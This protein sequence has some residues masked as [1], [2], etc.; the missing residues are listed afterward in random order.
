LTLSAIK[1]S[2]NQH[3]KKSTNQSIV[4]IYKII[5]RINQKKQQNLLIP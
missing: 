5:N 2:T 1:K 3:I 4:V